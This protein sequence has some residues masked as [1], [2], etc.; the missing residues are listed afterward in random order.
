MKFTQGQRVTVLSLSDVEQGLVYGVIIHGFPVKRFA[1]PDVNHYTVK[2]A[3]D[4]YEISEED[5]A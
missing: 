4:T 3:Y 1:E 2:V 5:L